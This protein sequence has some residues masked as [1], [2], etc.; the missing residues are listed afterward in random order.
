MYSNSNPRYIGFRVNRYGPSIT[1]AVVGRIGTTLVPD[2]Q[3]RRKLQVVSMRHDNTSTA[4]K[5]RP[6]P[7]GNRGIGMYLCKPIP[8]RKNAT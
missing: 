8:T 2:A 5:T 3:K 6:I 7:T 4:P 1:S